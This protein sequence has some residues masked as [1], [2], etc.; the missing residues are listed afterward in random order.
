MTLAHPDGRPIRLAHVTNSTAARA[1]ADR[2]DAA[3]APAPDDSATGDPGGGDGTG[4]LPSLRFDGPAKEGLPAAWESNADVVVSY[5][6]LGATVRIVAPLLGTKAED[7]GLVVVNEG[8]SV[9][10]PVLGGH[11]QSANRVAE[12]IAEVLGGAAAVTTATDST[13]LPALDTLGWPFAGDMAGVT[14]SILEDRPVD[15]RND[16]DWPLPEFPENVH[17]EAADPAGRVVVTDA[18]PAAVLAAA[19]VPTVVLTPPSL[20]VGMGCKRDTPLAN[21]RTHLT[22][23]LAANGLAVGAVATLTSVDAKADEPGLQALA[24]ELGVPLCTYPA[25][26]LDTQNVP[27]PSDAPAK[28]VGTHSVSEASVLA[29]GAELLVTKQKAAASTVA[30]GRARPRGRL[31]VIGLGAGAPDLIT[32]RA[33]DR[34]LSADAVVGYTV[35]IDQVRDMLRPGVHRAVPR[36]H[37]PRARPRRPHG[38]AGL[39]RRPC[40]LRHGQPHPPGR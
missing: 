31:A 40:H 12:A 9:V 17:A 39:L 19:E 38:G 11:A 7:P 10:V 35:Y 16:V 32:P 15:L 36:R 26:L 14:R 37:G 4:Q 29:D 24:A 27:T 21:L 33:R 8:G 13:G 6:A 22:D 23:V 25:E 30:I 2:I 3:L 34:I 18:D 5:L 1:S 28:A 20:A